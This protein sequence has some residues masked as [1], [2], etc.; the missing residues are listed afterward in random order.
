ML[1][2]RKL[3]RRK[4]VASP[5]RRYPKEEFARRGNAIYERDI[6]PH[7]K[8]EDD[9]KVLAID[10]E[11]GEYE[12]GRSELA[13]CDRLHARVPGAQVWLMRVGSPYLHRVGF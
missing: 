7:L 9:G 2:A 4:L 10:I 6:R 3:N 1:A 5:E 8:L 11:T 12:I 13:V